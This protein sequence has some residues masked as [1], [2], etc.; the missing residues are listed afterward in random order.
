MRQR[1][2]TLL[3]WLLLIAPPAAAQA[4]S[5]STIR[6]I[7]ARRVATR[8]AAGIVVGLVEGDRARFIAYGNRAGDGT[9][10]LDERTVFEIGSATKAFTGILLAEMAQRGE[11]S[12]DQALTSLLPPEVGRVAGSR[13]GK[14]ITL[15]DLATHTSGLPRLPANLEPAEPEN[16]YAGYTPDRMYSFLAGYSLPRDPG[17]RY[18]YS[19]YGMGL[20][21]QV[22]ARRLALSYE[23]ALIARVLDPLEL[24]DTRITLNA[25]MQARLAQGHTASLST[26]KLWDLG[27]LEGAGAVR[28]TAADLI[29]FLQANLGPGPTA[30]GA[31]LDSAQQPRRTTPTANLSIGLGWHLLERNGRRIIW[32][33]GQTGGY[34][35]FI[36]FD[37]ARRAA[38]A[39]LAN[40]AHD[41][42]DIGL[43]LLDSSLR[44]RE[45]PPAVERRELGL[46]PAELDRFVGEYEL[47]PV[48]SIVVTK[49][50]GFL[51]AQ[52]TGQPKF[53]I[54]AEARDRF[55]Y[56][57]VDAQLVF[58][59]DSGGRVTGLT[60]HQA[61]QAI[62]G[63]K[64]R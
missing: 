46:D 19:N 45:I 50:N 39:V 10:P 32:H 41:I 40:S 23:Q 34:H 21:G 44:L 8:Q 29:R 22:L 24:S 12:L 52:A 14:T 17:E 28:S 48:F 3:G 13:N 47:A 30:I 37:R 25:G 64:V 18:E 56:K 42:D 63:R 35:S 2:S 9:S 27:A 60:V 11:I 7:L 16:P 1:P 26:Q 49:E 61:G 4:P 36:A 58:V 54:F 51:W 33:N 15:L 31:A 62:P 20:L 55:F 43:H 38:V 57:V 53:Q 6:D 59:V 5:D